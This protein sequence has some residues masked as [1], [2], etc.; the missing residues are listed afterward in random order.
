[1]HNKIYEH[2]VSKE[3]ILKELS[4]KIVIVVDKSYVPEIETNS[5]RNSCN[6]DL[7]E[8]INIYSST[9]DL[10][11]FKI[12]QQCEQQSTPLQI[13][14]SQK[15]TTNIDSLK[16]VNLNDIISSNFNKLFELIKN[17]S[18]QIV[19]YK[20]NKKDRALNVYE[21]FFSDNGKRAFVPFYNVFNYF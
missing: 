10:Q 3:T 5:C 8:W 1:M 15:K 18:V 17:H 11:N 2:D 6:T 20:F 4:G 16:M 21:E 9:N 7:V 13:Q 12:N 19:P 14:D